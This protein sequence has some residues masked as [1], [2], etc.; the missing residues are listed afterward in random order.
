MTTDVQGVSLCQ[1]N[2]TSFS[3][4]CIFLTG[5]TARG[6]MYT[7]V[8]TSEERVTGRIWREGIPVREK[9]I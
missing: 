6:C 5:S 2:E 9:Q 4:M 3:I 1:L 8:S 7:L